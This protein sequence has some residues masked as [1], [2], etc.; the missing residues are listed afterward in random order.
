MLNIKFFLMCMHMKTCYVSATLNSQ[1]GYLFRKRM[2]GKQ[3]Q[4][5][6][7]HDEEDGFTT[8]PLP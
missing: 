8:H 1:G 5:V 2:C 7:G 3:K 6:S 4:D